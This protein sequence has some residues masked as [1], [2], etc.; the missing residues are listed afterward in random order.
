MRHALAGQL[1]QQAVGEVVEIVQALA[2]IGIGLALQFRARVVLHALHRRLGG[3]ARFQRLAQPPQPAA[4]IGEHADGFEH[5]AMLAHAVAVAA[6]DQLVDLLAHGLDRG[7][8]PAQFRLGIFRDQLLDDDSRLVQHD[9]AKPDA[10]ADRRALQGHGLLQA[11]ALARLGER[12]Q[13]AR[14]DHLGQQH[15]R[16]LQRLDLFLGIGAPRPVLHHED[17]ERIAAAQD[18][19]AQEGL[20][21]FLA[22]LGPVREGRMGL[23]VGERERLRLFGDQADEALARRHGGEMDRLAVQA[24]GGVELELAVGARHID[25][26]DFGDHVRGD[27][28]DDPIETRLR[29][30]RLRHDLAKPAQ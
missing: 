27:M 6:R 2:Q 24:F 3:E 26:A 12:L 8:E 19:H 10:F 21:D 1:A 13:F 15:G 25:R 11:E 17:A 29:V 20:I 28:N 7:V 14:G 16:R 22:G 4:V 30:H 5:V 9:M 18:R 23:R